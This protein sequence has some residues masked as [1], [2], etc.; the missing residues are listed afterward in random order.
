MNSTIEILR[1]AVMVATASGI[2]AAA[3]TK[4]RTP[5]M[6][7]FGSG[8]LEQPGDAHTE[9]VADAH[10][11]AMADSL[12]V[13]DD[14]E[15]F[16]E[17]PHQRNER[18]GGERSKLLQRQIDAAKLERD[19]DRNGVDSGVLKPSRLGR[20]NMVFH[21]PLPGRLPAGRRRRGEPAAIGLDARRS[22]QMLGDDKNEI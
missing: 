20:I 4:I 9:A 11:R 1:N 21:A 8:M 12:A 22:D 15:R 3:V 10:D 17:R 6:L 2:S 5:T 13:G 7:R 14:V 19:P 16:V 18:A